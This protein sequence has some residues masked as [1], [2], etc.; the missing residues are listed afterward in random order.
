M[1]Q[2]LEHLPQ[3]LPQQEQLAVMRALLDEAKSHMKRWV[4][5]KD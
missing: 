2:Q 3:D 4:T 5:E 1:Q